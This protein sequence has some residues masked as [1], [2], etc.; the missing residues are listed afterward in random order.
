[1]KGEADI[2]DS[3]EMPQAYNVLAMLY[4]LCHLVFWGVCSHSINT[5]VR[6][7]TVFPQMN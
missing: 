5:L 1:M 3:H 4:R 6:A 2:G 7:A